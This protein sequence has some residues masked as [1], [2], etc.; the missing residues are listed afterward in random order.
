MARRSSI[1]GWIALAILLV[2]RAAMADVALLL[3]EPYG[4]YGAFNPTGHAAVYLSRV[5]ADTPTH[6]RLCTPGEIGVVLNR[7]GDIGGHDWIAV[8]LLGYL[9]AVDRADQVP[10]SANAAEVLTL[11]DAY[12]HTH[13]QSIAPDRPDGRPPKG[14]WI[15]IIGAAYDRRV[16]GFSLTTDEAADIALIADFNRKPNVRRFNLLF[17]NCADFAKDLINTYYPH[18][19]H[20]NRIADFGLTTPKQVAKSFVQFGA[21]HP[22]LSLAAFGVAQI[23]G[24]RALTHGPKGVMEMFVK[25]K[26]YLI[27]MVA[28]PLWLPAGLAGGYLATGQFNPRAMATEVYGPDD[29]ERHAPHLGAVAVLPKSGSR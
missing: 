15:E 17:R 5:C 9:Y 25:S 12:R 1:R 14:N 24:N 16:D 20:S 21:H 7:Y 28:A 19:V 8:P 6:L 11:R 22:E 27:P 23:P 3:G 26:K 4:A 2:P 13:L 29:V 18:A 10:A